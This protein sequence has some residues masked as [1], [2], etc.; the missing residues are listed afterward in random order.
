[1]MVACLQRAGQWGLALRCAPEG[2]DGAALRAQ[3]LTD[4]HSWRLDAAAA[5]RAAISEIAARRPGLATYLSAQL[6]YWDRLLGPLS[7]AGNAEA[8]RPGPEPAEA[9]AALR[10]DPELGA[11]ATFWHA[12][13]LENLHGDSGAAAAGYASARDLALA[14]GDRLLESYAVR[15]L[16]GQA[17]QA[18]DRNG[19]I[20]LARYSLY[21]RAACGARPQ[22]AAAQALLADTLGDGAEAAQL[23]AVAASTAA[24]LGLTW[25]RGEIF[26]S[27]SR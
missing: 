2:P 9:F 27:G 3:V 17:L 24:E 12:V 5:A 1:M 7:E 21:L 10:G 19:A 23:R 14:G 20:A 8:A 26:P 18:G 4:R 15:H 6:E 16:S 11:W 25:L 22:V 13:T